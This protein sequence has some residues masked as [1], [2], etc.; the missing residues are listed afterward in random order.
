MTE[1]QRSKFKRRAV[2]HFN[3][4]A[5]NGAPIVFG[6]LEGL[7]DAAEA[8]GDLELKEWLEAEATRRYDELARWM[9]NR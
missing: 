9:V 3:D 2:A 7:K 4:F 8:L 5:K 6:R 1:E